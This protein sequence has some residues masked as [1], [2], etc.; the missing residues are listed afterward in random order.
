MIQEI[1]PDRGFQDMHSQNRFGEKYLVQVDADGFIKPSR[2]HT[3]PDI[4]I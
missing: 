2:I 1:Y 4:N 3:Q